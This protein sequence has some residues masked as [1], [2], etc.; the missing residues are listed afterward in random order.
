M[1]KHIPN[2]K[3]YA[4]VPNILDE[5]FHQVCEQIQ[6]GFEIDFETFAVE[7][8]QQHK[9]YID[10]EIANNSI[11]NGKTNNSIE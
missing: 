3:G 9:K 8:I 1:H 6:I 7:T 4:D 2:Y 11:P 5:L 10:D